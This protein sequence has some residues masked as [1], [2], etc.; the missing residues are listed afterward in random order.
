VPGDALPAPAPLPPVS[1]P[2]EPARYLPEVRPASLETAP[3]PRPATA[4]IEL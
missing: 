3:A 4:E 1:A 2:A